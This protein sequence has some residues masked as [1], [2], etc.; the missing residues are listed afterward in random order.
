MATPIISTLRRNQ[1]YVLA[2]MGVVLII[3]WVIGPV[4]VDYFGGASRG[5]QQ[6]EPPVVQW[7]KGGTPQFLTKDDLVYLRQEHMAV[8]DFVNRVVKKAMDRGLTPQ[9]P[10]LNVSPNQRGDISLG[11]PMDSSEATVVNIQLFAERGRELGVRVDKPAMMAYLR[12]L[13]GFSEDKEGDFLEL[14]KET[15]DDAVKSG[16]VISVDTLLAALRKEL[17]AQQAQYMFAVSVTNV[18][19]GELWD[20][21]KQ[22]NLRYKIEAYPIDVEKLKASFKVAD[23]KPEELMALFN[24][25]KDRVPDP[26]TPEP[27]F[28][29]PHRIAFGYCT[30]D[31]EVFLQI[32]KKNVPEAKALERYE[33]GIAQGGFRKPPLL[34]P[35]GT[36]KPNDVKPGDTK[37]E[38]TKPGEEKPAG[39]E[40]KPAE[41]EKK[42]EPKPGESKPAEEKP[43][44]KKAC[45]EEPAKPGEEKPA[46]EKAP[47]KEEKKPEPAKSEPA[48]TEPAE[49]DPAKTP[50][51]AAPAGE[52]A[53][54]PAKTEPKEEIEHRKYEEVRDEILTELA[55][56][57]AMQLRDEAVRSAID[58]LRTY[59]AKLKRYE[60][61]KK[62]KLADVENPGEFR[63]EAFARKYKFAYGK[64]PLFDE[65]QAATTVLGQNAMV[66]GTQGSFMFSQYAF[67][68]G[69]NLYD[70]LEAS[71]VGDTK[72]IHWRIDD[73][74]ERAVELE[75]SGS[76]PPAIKAQVEQAWLKEKAFEAAKKRA[77]ELVAKAQG[78]SLRDLVGKGED[79]KVVQPVPFSMF[80]SNEVPLIFGGR[81]EFSQ[82][83][84]IPMAGKEFMEKVFSL[85][86]GE[87]GVAVDQ[88]HNVVYAVRVL[89]EQPSLEIRREMFVTA[90]QRG[91]F[92]DLTAFASLE[93][94]GEMQSL[95]DDLEKHF[96]VKWMRPA[97]FGRGGDE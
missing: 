78:T 76:L 31:F 96:S 32:A 17:T 69:P 48:K 93:K 40:K 45:E 15:V 82:P 85:K 29:I 21:H 59:S 42:E 37:P 43:V 94:R 10:G 8:L 54:D 22:L 4:A 83:N 75:P 50:D 25:G 1:G 95:F 47:A 41:P 23:A 60:E 74:P 56:P 2:V 26:E 52:K 57:E 36:E 16:Q 38:E 30:V 86:P 67:T 5:R 6:A 97:S 12:G 53:E 77:E 24:K 39:E 44:E 46:E 61:S 34:I 7:N 19:T 28:K 27:G 13:S 88:P 71:S 58:E 3:T 51:A 9:A 35:P 14:A 18:S 11:L 92:S 81:P 70:P 62:D 91:Q 65:H 20:Y 68:L 63:P 33:K 72:F 49:T 90:L 55:Q 64:T 80:T 84:G 73:Q 89:G 87:A 66:Q 79:A